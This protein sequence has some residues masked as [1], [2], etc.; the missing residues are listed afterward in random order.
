MAGQNI[1]DLLALDAI[2]D[3]RIVLVSL[4]R[5]WQDRR[6]SNSME[7]ILGENT[8]DAL[9]ISLVRKNTSLLQL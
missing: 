4:G 6:L 2:N 8:L 7:I 9:Y 3:A 5:Y 1:G